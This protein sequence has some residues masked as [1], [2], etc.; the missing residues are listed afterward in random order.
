MMKSILDGKRILAVDDE[1]DILD[2]IEEEITDA[3]LFVFLTKPLAMMRPGHGTV[4]RSR[5]CPLER[6][7]TGISAERQTW[8]GS[9]IT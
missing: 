9:S 6:A 8:P 7:C 2:T 1:P 3:H 5:M 4:R